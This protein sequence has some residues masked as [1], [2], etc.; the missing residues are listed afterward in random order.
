MHCSDRHRREKYGT[1]PVWAS[2]TAETRT[3]AATLLQ[4]GRPKLDKVQIT[5]NPEVIAMAPWNADRAE[6][7]YN[8]ALPVYRHPVLELLHRSVTY[9]APEASR[10]NLIRMG[11]DGIFP[12]YS[13][14]DALAEMFGS[15]R[16]TGF[17]HPNCKLHF[18][19]HRRSP[20]FALLERPSVGDNAYFHTGQAPAAIDAPV[21]IA[22]FIKSIKLA[23]EEIIIDDPQVLAA[24]RRGSGYYIDVPV[25]RRNNLM[26][27]VLTDCQKISLPPNTKIV[28]LVY[29]YESQISHGVRDAGASWMSGRLRFVPNLLKLDLSLVG[30]EGIVMKDGFHDMGTEDARK[31]TSLRAYFDGLVSRNLTSKTFDSFCPRTVDGISYIQSLLLDFS[32]YDMRETSELQA[33]HTYTGT[34]APPGW[35]VMCIAV[36]QRVLTYDEKLLWIMKDA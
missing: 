18:T 3:R 20:I 14:C 22:V 9:E 35:S 15:S 19:L 10:P 26:T 21:V 33:F 27:N 2:T 5:A 25:S 12:F 28:Y 16:P 13:Q 23:Y 6:Q 7:S 32:M 36:V 34:G 31:S 24:F 29:L 8:P 11:L 17:I 1:N 30:K 4:H